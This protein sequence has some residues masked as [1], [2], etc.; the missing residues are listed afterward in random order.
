MDSHGWTWTVMVGHGWAWLDMVGHGHSWTW[1]VIVGHGWTYPRWDPQSG[2]QGKR[3]GTHIRM[4]G[5]PRHDWEASHQC[6][7]VF[8]V[9]QDFQALQPPLHV[10]DV[11]AA[12][13]RE[14]LSLHWSNIEV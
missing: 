4:R 7:E 13:E 2:T 3:R 9:E 10:R 12:F 8:L 1:T 6:Q 14:R 5:E 11:Q